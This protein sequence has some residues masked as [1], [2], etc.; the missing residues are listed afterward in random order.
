MNKINS[1]S[2]NP[3]LDEF[4]FPE[5]TGSFRGVLVHKK[6]AEKTGVLQ[7]YFEVIDG[8]KIILPAYSENGFAP[9]KEGP[10]FEEV[11]LGTEW[12]GEF[13]KS[14]NGF[15]KWMV[16]QK[17]VSEKEVI[18]CAKILLKN[19]VN[20]YLKDELEELIVNG[21]L[22]FNEDIYKVVEKICEDGYDIRE[23]GLIEIPHA[24]VYCFGNTDNTKFFDVYLEWFNE[25]SDEVTVGFVNKNSCT[26]DAESIA[27]AI[28]KYCFD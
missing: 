23:F 16:A 22:M 24:C 7:C 11:E 26:E 25:G 6:R 21:G 13:T 3:S 18:A 28:E 14:K 17:E 19:T 2:N 12:Y 15:T 20:I 1:K 5:K 8:T 10:G 27:Q 9:K 4:K